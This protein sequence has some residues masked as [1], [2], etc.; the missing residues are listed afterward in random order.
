MNKIRIE[1]GLVRIARMAAASGLL[2]SL[3]AACAV[4]PDY[5]RPDVA[6]PAAFK[7]AP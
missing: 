5:Q 6:T 7:E 4:G 2:V 1:N 3:L